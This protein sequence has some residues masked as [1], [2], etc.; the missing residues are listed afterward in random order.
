MN[1]AV[2]SNKQS[3][4]GRARLFVIS[5]PSG[6]GK[7]TLVRKLLARN[8]RV[9]FSISYTTRP[10]RERERNG[11][12]YFFVDKDQF[13]KMVDD[14]EF[15]EHAT[16][17]DN[18]Y[19]T[20]RNQVRAELDAGQ[21]VLLEIDW[22]G[23]QQIRKAWSDCVSIFILPPSLNE[24]ER[25]LRSRATDSEAIIN[26]RLQDSISD[27]AHWP[28]FDHVIINDDLGSALTELEA[29]IDGKNCETDVN[30]LARQQQISDCGF[31]I[32]QSSI[33][34]EE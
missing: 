4:L 31:A 9:K 11:D 16:V 28:E 1:K 10:A 21:H 7:T 34:E 5:A 6:A 20:S 15:L 29:V 19:G 32:N 14:N 17:F 26:R 18:Y 22:Q 33:N 12:D 25:R 27:I 24:L 2:N 30:N 13:Q 3:N 23:A 8:P